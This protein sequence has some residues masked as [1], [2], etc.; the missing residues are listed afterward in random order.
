[1]QTTTTE[2]KLDYADALREARE[3]LVETERGFLDIPADSAFI[4]WYAQSARRYTF[5]S[6][7]NFW[8][9]GK[10]A[11]LVLRPEEG[12]V[13]SPDVRGERVLHS[14]DEQGRE[15]VPAPP[16]HSIPKGVILYV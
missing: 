7:W 2:P 12:E 3:W 10:T 9:W 13:P 15:T 4:S 1:M 16:S 5:D 14:S 6:A 8:W 11:A